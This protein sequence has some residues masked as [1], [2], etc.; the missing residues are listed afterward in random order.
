VRVHASWEKHH[1][2]VV[3][4]YFIAVTL[5]RILHLVCW[6]CA[7]AI[8]SCLATAWQPRTCRAA[9]D[10]LNPADIYREIDRRN[11]VRTGSDESD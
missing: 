8:K 7:S 2:L 11:A 4:A 5:E 10:G 9:G 3:S 6:C 1:Q